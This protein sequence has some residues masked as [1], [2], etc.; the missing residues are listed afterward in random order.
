MFLFENDKCPVCEKEF[1]QGDDIVVCPDC[2][3]PHHRACYDKEKGCANK[4]LHNTDFKFERSAARETQEPQQEEKTELPQPSLFSPLADVNKT[5]EVNQLI[6]ESLLD[7]EKPE[8]V[9]IDG[10][11]VY[12]ASDVIKV[13][14]NYYLPRFLKNKGLN[15][16]WGA[17]LFGQFYY[18][19]RKMYFQGFFFT[20]INFGV[21]LIIEKFFSKTVLGWAHGFEA[22]LAGF[23]PFFKNYIGSMSTENKAVFDS[24]LI[25]GAV[26]VVLSA[27][28]AVFANRLYKK[29]V[30]STVK[31]VDEKLKNGGSFAV[32]PFMMGEEVHLSNEDMRKLFLA[33]QGGVTWLVPALIYLAVIFLTQIQI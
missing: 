11:S 29:K 28:M 16:N 12:D 19:F 1:N 20:V 18:F 15:W 27:V 25:S 5:D 13:N 33:K 14:V 10:V 32:S 22:W 26:S 3:T 17:F 2:G 7:G 24:L 6:N 23:L 4:K 31:A 8:N 21:N 9:R 30:V